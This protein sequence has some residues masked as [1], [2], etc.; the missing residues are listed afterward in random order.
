MRSAWKTLAVLIG[1][2]LSFAA[3]VCAALQEVKS[4]VF[5]DDFRAGSPDPLKRIEAQ[6]VHELAVNPGDKK[7]KARLPHAFGPVEE[8]GKPALH[9][10]GGF[11]TRVFYQGKE[12]KDFTLEVDVKKLKGSYAGVVVR[13]NWRVYFQ[14]RGFVCLNTDLRGMPQGRL[15]QSDK[16]F[17]GYHKL[18]VVCA[19]PLLHV[20]VDDEHIVTREIPDKPGQVGFYSHGRGEAFYRNF[21]IDTHVPAPAYLAVSPKAP[22]DSLVFAP[23]EEV[24]LTFDVT[25]NAEVS[26]TV[27]TAAA[28]KDW[29]GNVLAEETQQTVKLGKGTSRVVFNMGR[30]ASGF[31]CVSYTATVGDTRFVDVNDLPLAVQD[32]GDGAF[33]TPVIPVSA[34]SKYFGNTTPIYYNTYQHAIA[35]KLKDGG[36]NA[37]VADPMFNRTA[38]DIYQSYGIA[39]IARSA[40]FLDHPAAIATLA[41]DEPKPDQI[42]ALKKSYEKIA[43]NSGKPV[44]TCM[45]G[46]GTGMGGPHD[47]VTIWRKL[48]A[49]V[50]AF[51][52]YGIKKSYYS[53]LHDLKYKGVLPL[54]SVMRIVE[55]SDDADWWFVP[56]SFGATHHE[57]YFHNPTPAEMR[58]LM[59]MAMANGCDGLMLWCLQ[60]W[61]RWPALIEQKS[62]QPPDGKFQAA[63][64]VARLIGKHAE[65]L[66]ALHYGFFEVRNS[67]PIYIEAVPRKTKAGHACIYVVNKDAQKPA[68]AT[69]AFKGS[70]ARD[71][72]SGRDLAVTPGRDGMG[73]LAVKLGPCEAALL[74]VDVIP[75][76]NEPVK[77]LEGP[78]TLDGALAARAKA[79]IEESGVAVLRLKIPAKPCAPGD[80]IGLSRA[81]DIR[82]L[83]KNVEANPR[84]LSWSGLLHERTAEG[85]LPLQ[86]ALRLADAADAKTP[87]WTV[88]PKVGE[89]RPSPGE[90]RAMLHLAL[91]YGSKAILVSDAA[92]PDLGRIVSEVSDVVS[93]HGRTVASLRYAGLDVRCK[94]A[95][96]AAIPRQAGEKGPLCVYAVNLDT[97]KEVAA[98]LLLWDDVWDWTKA[99]DVFAGTALEVKPR[100]K[101]GYLSVQVTLKPG[102]GKLVETDAKVNK[103][104]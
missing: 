24:R 20:Y 74:D 41:S 36:F 89:S 55:A 67:N 98:D 27:T 73:A 45:V 16:R 85:Y 58:G 4:G 23:G 21:R 87:Y 8:G 91:A 84:C 42:E 78:A 68:G 6:D 104:K 12:F 69:L 2:G 1:L 7:N 49:R 64:E 35:R 47:P 53:I 99:Q 59:H 13:D 63:S 25:N 62:L 90:L 34:Y 40:A 15:F 5:I 103:K 72:F 102:E 52:W 101:E 96:V 39:T 14:M 3:P 28:V 10:V 82:K 43:A 80:A 60:G 71:L 26:Q 30:L 88:Y 38:V 17:Q 22:G 44:T 54:S 61:G 37:I 94:N 19:G 100:D 86:S 11:Q 48:D 29:E 77:A 31:H 57:G 75:P 83:W 70:K 97:E 92:G 51:R 46:E 66:A 9:L 56:P 76:P 18:K 32:R 65:L 79:E 50:R 95:M 93:P 81:D 33:K